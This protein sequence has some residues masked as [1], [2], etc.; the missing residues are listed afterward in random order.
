MPGVT[1]FPF[2][3]AHEIARLDFDL[4]HVRAVI[5]EDLRGERP[6]DDR[7]Q[8]DDAHAF[9]GAARHQL[10]SRDEG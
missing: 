8:V 7:G 2:D 10:R 3:R 9:E 5:G 1:E 6:D 4:D